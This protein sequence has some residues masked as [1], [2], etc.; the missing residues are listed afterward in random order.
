MARA[1]HGHRLQ[2][3]A[4]T[5]EVVKAVRKST[6]PPLPP[7]V[8]AVMCS[9]RR[10]SIVVEAVKLRMVDA[11]EVRYADGTLLDDCATQIVSQGAPP[12]LLL[13]R[14]PYIT[15]KVFSSRC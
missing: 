7:I 11:V 4:A 13:P 5:S 9:P 15:A 10:P 3:A 2:P 1:G 6:P 12:H 8:E 14:L